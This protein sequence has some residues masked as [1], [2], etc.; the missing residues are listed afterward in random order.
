MIG[1]VKDLT[2]AALG[3]RVRT[4][5]IPT[6]PKLTNTSGGTDFGNQFDTGSSGY[7]PYTAP[8]SGLGLGQIGQTYG[9][10]TSTYAQMLASSGT[11]GGGGKYSGFN[12]EGALKSAIAGGAINFA[13]LVPQNLR[14]AA[15]QRYT[16]LNK[17]SALPRK[18]IEQDLFGGTIESYKAY[19]PYKQELKNW[20][21]Q[22]AA[23]AEEYVQ[24]AQQIESTPISSL[25]QQIASS[26]YGQS[27]DWATNEFKDMDTQ[28]ASYVRDQNYL[29]QFG[30][31]Y[32]EYVT[33]LDE[34]NRTRG[35]NTQVANDALEKFTGLK[36]SFVS[37]VTART[38]D[39]LAA[40]LSEDVKYRLPGK[41]YAEN[42]V[43][44]D[45]GD[46]VIKKA[47]GFILDRDYQSAYDMAQSMEEEGFPDAA[48]I[49]YAM[50]KASGASADL[51]NRLALSGIVTP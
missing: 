34:A 16:D 42:T 20:Y 8:S 39:Q 18:K 48:Y 32:D 47:R 9:S 13:T 30:K 3:G 44:V 33:A 19:E 40:V 12:T 29:R 11:Q 43:D 28:Y 46:N 25:A 21:Q 49:V 24:T 22:N 51:K 1:S 23:P 36:G 37:T 41:P 17:L 26:R 45:R 27:P 4:T 7:I 10:P 5:T 38:P 15:E 2:K 35:I 6:T 50:L 14:A 31:T